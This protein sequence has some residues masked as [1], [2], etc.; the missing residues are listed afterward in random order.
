[1]PTD[2]HSA[3]KPA[4][5]KS[6]QKGYSAQG[7]PA[8]GSMYPARSAAKAKPKSAA[9]K[10]EYAPVKSAASDKAKHAA[11][12]A[13]GPY[14]KKT[15]D[16]DAHAAKRQAANTYEQRYAAPRKKKKKFKFKRFFKKLGKQISAFSAKLVQVEEL[17]Q[18]EA[19]LGMGMNQNELGFA[20]KQGGSAGDV[21]EKI[22]KGLLKALRV[23]ARGI[24]LGIRRTYQ[25]LMKLPPRT[26]L[27]GSSALGLVLMT[28]IILAIALP[29]KASKAENA[30]QLAAFTALQ[31]EPT[32]LENANSDAAL[33]GDAAQQDG[34]TDSAIDATLPADVEGTTT[35]AA[36][37]IAFTGEMTAGDDGEII[38]TIQTRL[39][40]LGYMDSD[41]P[42]QHFGPLTQ[43][44]LKAF[45][46]HNG[47]GDDGILG[48]ATYT[49]LMNAEAKVYVMQLGD[50]GPDVEGVQQ[51]L[52][53]LGYLDNKANI[54]G[55][56]GEKTE[57]AAKTFQKKNHL[58]ADGKV[59]SKTL[60]MLYGEDVVG[61]AYKLGDENP[62]IKDC[63]AALKR[64][65][66][67]TFKP[68]GVMGKATVSAIKAFQ[69]A[70][71]LTRDGQLGPV[72]R[73]MI[74][75]GDAQEMVMQ[76]GDYGTDV[77][78]MQA[79]LAKLN[80]L[81]SANATGYF[82]EITQDAVKAFQKRAGLTA[83][84][85]VGGV[86]LTM[87]NSSS[88][89][90]AASPPSTKK[91]NKSTGSSGG[92]SSG[93]SSSGGSTSSASDKT[94]VEKL[95]A[96]AESKI[97]SKYVR[98]AK[99][100]NTFD[101]SG[102]V[103]WCL[104]NSGVSTSYMTSI[105]WRSTSRFS[106][107]S[108]MG[109]IERGDILVFSGSTASDGHVGIYLGGGKMIDASSSEGQVRQSSSVLNSGGYWS[110]HF[111][112]AYRVF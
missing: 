112:C 76:L 72:T 49:A 25:F 21:W 84:G 82:G 28:T 19:S 98:G 57:E 75:S 20:Q 43:S 77:K 10:G 39:M 62:V 89:K 51:R 95:V 7:A 97:G 107:V 18:D 35:D 2:P 6:K 30:E 5:G 12:D 109:S 58:T 74:L 79:R 56:F 60:E 55:K 106:R 71:G 4:Q 23:V 16:R 67:V 53:E 13:R 29:G 66:Y 24:Y 32:A 47:L 91:E 34:V 64:L 44:A 81:A 73:D 33:T 110:T 9:G 54:Q 111:I 11:Q 48:Q 45:Q 102:F 86:T 42:T 93:G 85:K 83:D 59:G 22:K 3:R 40:E 92:S 41:E 52:Y 87:M 31:S 27:I 90:K 36:Q 70:N 26:L 8:R 105:A 63:Q 94:G 78:N 17:P 108:S 100:S 104:K 69:Q 99:G 101:C 14:E 65:G 88:A 96:L 68:D 103:Y 37:P 61:N 46:R 38:S 1:M 50:S 15:H 80:Y